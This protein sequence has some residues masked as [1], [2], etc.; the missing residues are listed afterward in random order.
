MAKS[1]QSNVVALAPPVVAAPAS[2]WVAVSAAEAL[3]A[4]GLIRRR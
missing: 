3:F 2:S 1:F 4:A